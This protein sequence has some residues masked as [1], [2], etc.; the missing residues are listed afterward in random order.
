[1]SFYLLEGLL[2]N[3]RQKKV[4]K[5]VNGKTNILEIGCGKEAS[6]LRSLSKDK[7]KKL[8]GI[9]PQLNDKIIKPD[10]LTLI[11]GNVFDKINLADNSV[12]CV[13]MLAVLE[14][15]DYSQ[16]IINEAY[17]ILTPGGIICLTVP[18]HFAKNIL[19]VLSFLRFIDPQ[20]MAEHKR[21]F[22]RKDL[23]S[24]AKQAGFV[25]TK[26]E[27]FQ[28]GCNNFFVGYKNH[29]ENS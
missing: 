8:L 27:Y 4:F 9:N 20:M 26:H 7:N 15:L 5:A 10:N 22:N 12:D 2:S 24:M 13:I 14:H 29:G 6:F 11:E 19:R 18:T 1:M 28:L 25:K 23:E 3:W 16:E 17:R 21:Y